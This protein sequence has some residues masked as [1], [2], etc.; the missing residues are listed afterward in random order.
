MSQVRPG[1]ILR[2]LAQLRQYWKQGRYEPGDAIV[3]QA[4]INGTFHIIMSGNAA[5]YL[6]GEP[7]VRVAQLVPGGF[8]GEMTCLTGEAASATV[9]AVDTVM[10]L[11]M[12]KEGLL[13]LVDAS[14]ELRR[15]L[16]QA[17]VERIK[18]SNTAVQTEA[19]R[20]SALAEA[21]SLD[22]LEQTE[23]MSKIKG[24][25]RRLAPHSG[26]V[27]I[28]GDSTQADPL[29]LK[30]HQDGKHK[31]GPILI[32]TNISLNWDTFE[33]QVR[34]AAGGTL[35]LRNAEKMTQDL[36]LHITL[37]TPQNTRIV[38]TATTL[39]ELP[40]VERVMLPNAPAPNP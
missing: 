12:D 2:E 35:V 7:R 17:M 22:L 31:D 34:A 3:R 37:S 27:A 30:L 10:T 1:S 8:F 36:L 32:L 23:Q 25:L 20:S 13:K 39:A 18:R 5:V 19:T 15:R 38:M 6:E 14:S 21:I 24:E 26:P 28:I 9:E 4:E 33:Q 11:A 29:A 16:I 40:G